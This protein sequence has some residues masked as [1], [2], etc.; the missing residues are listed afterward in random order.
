M[1]YEIMQ[2]NIYPSSPASRTHRPDGPIG[3]QGP[4][5]GPHKAQWA[6]MGSNE[7]QT[8]LMEMGPNSPKSPMGPTGSRAGGLTDGQAD[9]R[10]AGRAD[11]LPKCSLGCP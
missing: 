7:P 9:G 2:G 4:H 5:Y 1:I 11:G 3:F 8:T 10:T 6:P